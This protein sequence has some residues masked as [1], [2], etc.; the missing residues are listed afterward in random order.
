MTRPRQ[1]SLPLPVRRPATPPPRPRPA[2][3]ATFDGWTELTWD[4]LEMA[5]WLRIGLIDDGEG[6][7]E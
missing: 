1:P 3:V 7:P 4:G 6:T 5:E 2:G